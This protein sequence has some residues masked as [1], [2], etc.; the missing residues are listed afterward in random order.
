[1]GA[2]KQPVH[3]GD[4]RCVRACV[5]NGAC[6]DKSV[7]FLKSVRKRIY[8]IIENAFAVFIAIAAGY[9]AAHRLRADLHGL[10]LDTVFGK[11]ALQ[12]MQRGARVTLRARRTVYHENLQCLAH[13]RNLHCFK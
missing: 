5:I 7:G 6:D 8:N 3:A 12:L 9:T 2:E 11:N 13:T 4:E 10:G 1:M